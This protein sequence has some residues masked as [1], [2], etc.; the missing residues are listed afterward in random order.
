MWRVGQRPDLGSSDPPPIPRAIQPT[1]PVL[2]SVPC[3]ARW[4]PTTHLELVGTDPLPAPSSPAYRGSLAGVSGAHS[5]KRHLRWPGLACS[6]GVPSLPQAGPGVLAVGQQA[7]SGVASRDAW[8]RRKQPA[9]GW[10]VRRKPLL[11][12]GYGGAGRGAERAAPSGSRRPHSPRPQAL[13]PPTQVLL[14]QSAG[15]A[16]GVG[17]RTGERTGGGGE[18]AGWRER[19]RGGQESIREMQGRGE[20][21]RGV[22]TIAHRWGEGQREAERLAACL[23]GNRGG[24]SPGLVWLIAGSRLPPRSPSPKALTTRP[25]STTPTRPAGR[26]LLAPHPV[27]SRRLPQSLH[28]QNPSPPARGPSAESPSP[29]RWPWM[30]TAQPL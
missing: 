11:G 1:G 18:A 13:R 8:D 10:Q 6:S 22:H 5:S 27:P 7:G 14:W 17:E 12:G 20:E 29:L 19:Q 28:P 21:G 24:L 3:L 25:S 9:S 4:P 30:G 23:W 2:P 26:R 16:L 15:E